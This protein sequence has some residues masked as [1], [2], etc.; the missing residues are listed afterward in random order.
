MSST[1][2][3][4]SRRASRLSLSAALGLAA[5]LAA[6]APTMAQVPIVQP[7][8]PGAPTRELSAEQAIEIAD[9]SY[10][11]ADAL[12]M[13]DMIPHHNQAVQMAALVADRTNRPE[14]IDVAG[15]I[16]KSQKDEIE[17]M[18]QWLADRGESA[19]DPTAHEAMHTSHKMAG[20]ASPEQM[21]ELAATDGTDFDRLFLKL[22][23]KHHEGA[24]KMVE[25]LL[26]QPGSAYDPVLFEFTNDVT[27]GQEAEIERMNTLLVGLSDDPRA[28]LGAGFEDAEQAAMNLELVA[29]LPK[30]AGF[31]D[32]ANPAGLPPKPPQE[33]SPRSPRRGRL[34]ARTRHDGHARRGRCRRG[35]RRRAGDGGRG[36]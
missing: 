26:D 33:G 19:P 9:T 20:M 18:Q 22:M 27:N 35:R 29:S 14:L 5:I 6:T 23:I 3:F 32:P 31:F 34:R 11:P 1:S 13:Q 7:G 12:F 4:S 17:F 8:A 15:R 10:S 36:G 28:G 16:D 30:P 21:A 25:E 24:V 2:D